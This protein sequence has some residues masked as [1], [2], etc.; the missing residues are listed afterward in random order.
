MYRSLQTCSLQQIKLEKENYIS[1]KRSLI[2]PLK[3]SSVGFAISFLVIVK[4][5]IFKLKKTEKNAFNFCRQN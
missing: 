4:A 1:E 2:F 3:M 5:L